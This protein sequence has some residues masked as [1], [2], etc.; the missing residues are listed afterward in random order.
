MK[1]NANVFI[2]SD[3]VWLAKHTIG[4]VSAHQN[5]RNVTHVLSGPEALRAIMQETIDIIFLGRTARPLGQSELLAAIHAI[6]KTPI[7]TICEYR[8]DLV[9]CSTEFA[10]LGAKLTLQAP[11]QNTPTIRKYQNEL[12]W[13]LDVLLKGESSKV[14]SNESGIQKGAGFAKSSVP[15]TPE[16]VVIGVSTGGPD[17]LG[18]LLTKIP[19]NYSLPIVIVQ[20]I[21]KDFSASLVQG[22]N[23]KTDLCV[24]EAHDGDI[25]L[26][27]TVLVAAADRHVI[28][29]RVGR[30]LLTR[31][32]SG[33]KVNNVRPAA[34]VL[35]QSAAN[36]CGSGT[37]AVVLTGMGEDGRRG[38][39]AIRKCGGRIVAQDKATSVIWGMPGAVANAGLADEVLPLEAIPRQLYAWARN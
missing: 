20:H 12:Q 38:C 14:A 8:Q 22:L 39:E 23:R 32:N 4:T 25:A 26:P 17:A 15:P 35:F 10:E 6:S 34:D 30:S 13:Q 29:E 3:D 18:K 27:G 9:S 31:L 36:V 2:V 5:V 7:I 16:I 11:N 1:N 24:T 33:E 37:I 19:D 28:L 21:L